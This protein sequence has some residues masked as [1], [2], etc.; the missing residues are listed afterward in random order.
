MDS[1]ATNALLLQELHNAP[2]QCGQRR[3]H[4]SKLVFYSAGRV[5]S[6]VLNREVFIGVKLFKPEYRSYVESSFS[7][8]IGLI[9][10]LQE[11]APEL[12]PE[13]PEFYGLLE[14]PSGLVGHVTEDLTHDGAWPV[15]MLLR[16]ADLPDRFKQVAVN[17]TYWGEAMRHFSFVDD[18]RRLLDLDYAVLKPEFERIP[19]F[20]E[21]RGYRVSLN[22]PFAS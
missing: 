22:Y 16:Q 8:S 17:Q 20:D 14:D 1:L 15:E 2:M 6:E 9:R 11:F 18:K 21:V 19:L 13:L 12:L 10:T 4:S 5:H 3:G 7:T